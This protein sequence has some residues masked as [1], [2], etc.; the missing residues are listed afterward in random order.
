M[1]KISRSQ[2]Q[3]YGNDVVSAFN[4]GFPD[5]NGGT[6]IVYAELTN[7]HGEVSTDD[8][9]RIYYIIDG[10]GEFVVD[11]EQSSVKIGDVIPVPPNTTYNYWPT[12]GVLKCLL[13][14]EYFDASGLTK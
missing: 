13:Y 4:Y 12:K 6:S 2:A 1:K 9:A 7:I 5:V 8:R 3:P 14:M 11:G 10:V